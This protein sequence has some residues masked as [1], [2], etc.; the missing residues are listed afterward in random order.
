MITKVVI[1]GA[2]WPLRLILI[3]ISVFRLINN[4]VVAMETKRNIKICN[5]YFCSVSYQPS[6]VSAKQCLSRTIKANKFHIKL[7]LTICRS[8]QFMLPWILSNVKI[9]I[10]RREWQC[11]DI[12]TF[13]INV[14]QRSEQKKKKNYIFLPFFI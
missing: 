5:L 14:Q 11:S 1:C 10:C 6:V 12:F 9:Y 3:Y 13:T 4:I 8:G 7:L 2:M